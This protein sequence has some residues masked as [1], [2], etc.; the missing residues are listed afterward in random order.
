M[1]NL[2]PCSVDE[3]AGLARSRLKRTQ[4]QPGLLDGFIAETGIIPAPP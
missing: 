3:L 4:Y 2:A 1:G